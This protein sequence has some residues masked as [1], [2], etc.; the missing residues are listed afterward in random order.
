VAPDDPAL[1]ELDGA[2]PIACPQGCAP[3]APLPLVAAL[4][5][6]LAYQEY[7]N[8]ELLKVIGDWQQFMGLVNK[9]GLENQAQSEPL[10]E[11]FQWLRYVL[12]TREGQ[13]TLRLLWG[14]TPWGQ[15]DPKK[16]AQMAA[17]LGG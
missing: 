8:R 16:M 14:Q 7:A 10:P 4:K 5:L 13:T 2:F 3:A 9:S 12:S 15:L 6:Q 11:K 17:L 1:L